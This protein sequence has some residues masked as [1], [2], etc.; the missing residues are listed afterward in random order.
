MVSKIT[1]MPLLFWIPLYIAFISFKFSGVSLFSK[2]CVA[3][4]CIV[5]YVGVNDGLLNFDNR[6]I[7][8]L[9]FCKWIRCCYM[10]RNYDYNYHLSNESLININIIS[11]YVIESH[12]NIYWDL[13]ARRLSFHRVSKD[14]YL[15][16]GISPVWSSLPS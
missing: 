1:C 14:V 2:E 13:E 4:K 8:T 10:V 11:I 7:L 15:T 6:I 12:T 16:E 3:C 9:R 5:P